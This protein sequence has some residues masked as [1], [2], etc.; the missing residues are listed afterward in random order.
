MGCSSAYAGR[1]CAVGGHTSSG[2]A[3]A[4][5]QFEMR[6]IGSWVLLQALGRRTESCLNGAESL[7]QNHRAA[8][9][10]A[11]PERR[12]G[13][14]YGSRCVGWGG[15]ARDSEQLAAE[16]QQGRTAS[17]GKQP[18]VPDSD[19]STWQHVQTERRRNSST[20]RLIRRFLFLWAESRQ[21]KVTRPSASATSR[22]LEIATRCV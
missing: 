16:S 9:V 10:R 17:V 20:V 22:W 7:Q 19:E 11:T 4:C 15:L 2:G 1:S 5:C 21:R 12:R 14:T 8:T 3:G 6:K 18:E 13:I